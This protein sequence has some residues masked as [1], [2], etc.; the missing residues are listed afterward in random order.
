MTREE[1]VEIIRGEIT[2]SEHEFMANLNKQRLANLS[3]KMA[4]IS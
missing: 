1:R 3:G 2:S 4:L